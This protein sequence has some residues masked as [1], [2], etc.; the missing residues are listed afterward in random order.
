MYFIVVQPRADSYTAMANMLALAEVLTALH[1]AVTQHTEL[2]VPVSAAL[3]RLPLTMQQRTEAVD[4]MLRHLS[5]V[6]A[7]D[8][9]EV[10]FYIMQQ[11]TPGLHALKVCKVCHLLRMVHS[12]LCAE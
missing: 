9:A 5:S 8:A 7:A 11:C 6:P 4:N 10:T 12:S 1:S 2:A 3:K